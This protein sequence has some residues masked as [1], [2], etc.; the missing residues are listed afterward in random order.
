MNRKEFIKKAWQIGLASGVTFLMAETDGCCAPLPAAEEQSVTRG[1]IIAQDDG[2]ERISLR[3]I[4]GIHVLVGM[5]STDLAAAGIIDADLEAE[6]EIRLKKAG[7]KVLEQREASALLGQPFL[8]IQVGG[9]KVVDLPMYVISL[10]GALSQ[11]VTLDRDS[12]IRCSANTWS[13]SGVTA[14]AAQSLNQK[15]KSA[16]AVL[17]D[18]FIKDYLSANPK[19]QK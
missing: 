16:L 19:P 14:A 8:Y 9:T 12:T 18:Q 7:I 3:G 4:S 13:V 10:N 11:K 6:V 1:E 2:S 15:I 17:A 5:I